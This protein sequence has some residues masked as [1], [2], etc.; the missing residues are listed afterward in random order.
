MPGELIT[1]IK[2]SVK[3]L[4]IRNLHYFARQLP[5]NALTSKLFD[6]LRLPQGIVSSVNPK[7]QQKK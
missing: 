1:A 5:S 3:R 6:I 7:A 4:E 2:E